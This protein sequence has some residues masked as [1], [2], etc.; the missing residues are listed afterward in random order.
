MLERARLR[1]RLLLVAGLSLMPALPARASVQIVDLPVSFTVQNVN[2]SL[3]PC[4]TDGKT[5][6]IKGSLISPTPFPDS[7]TLYLHGGTAGEWMWHFQAV[8]GYDYATEMARLGHASVVIDMLGYDDSKTAT[9]P[10]GTEWCFGGNADTVH[11]MIEQLRTG[12]Y[13]L[14]GS[15]GPAFSRVALAGLSGG[16]ITA[17]VEAHS[18]GDIDALILIGWVDNLTTAG[19]VFTNRLLLDQQSGFWECRRGGEPSEDDGSGPL[20]YAYTWSTLEKQFDDVFFDVDPVVEAAVAPLINRD[21]CGY[22]GSVAQTV[23]V[24]N[25]FVQ[26]IT[27]PV[28]VVGGD[29][30]LFKPID[31]QIFARRFVRS[32]DVTLRILPGTGH[33]GVLERTA[34][35]FRTTISGWLNAR[36]F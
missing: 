23:F 1:R 2:R 35:L 18:F 10:I 22:L 30:D 6:E 36:G 26:T 29:H 28:L 21:P 31:F 15:A 32:G 27:A 8:P 13:E 34:P 17:D 25:V 3:V 24:N 19:P 7:V 4:A 5:Y 16:A 12:G 14:D 11:Q 20:G 9:G 33:V